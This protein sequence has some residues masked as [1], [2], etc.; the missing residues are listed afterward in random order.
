M[1]RS[2]FAM[3]F[4]AG[5]ALVV[6]LHPAAALCQATPSKDAPA[7][8]AAAPASPAQADPNAAFL[9]KASGIY[10]ST[11][12]Q[13]LTGF[14]CAVHPDWAGIFKTLEKK[15][16]TTADERTAYEKDVALLNSLK[17]T[18]HVR[19]TGPGSGMDWEPGTMAPPDPDSLEMVDHMHQATGQN[20]Q[21]FLQFW[22]PL[23]NG[24]V[25]PDT[26][27][28]ITVEKTET[29]HTIHAVDGSTN[30]TEVLD[31][32]NVL[33]EFIVEM[34]GAKITF[35]PTYKPTPNGLL[36]SSFATRIQPPGATAEKQQKMNVGVEYQTVKGFLVLHTLTMDDVGMGT[37][38]YTFD[39]CTVNPAP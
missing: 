39:G 12:K 2:G 8:A 38:A 15:P 1:F 13:G 26:T 29:G 23:V 9:A 21:G 36:V 33:K 11:T 3:P 7:P 22:T 19:L 28:G 25:I 18:L 16:A 6:A 14:D 27:S 5:I 31:T 37:F 4:A 24:S 17:I 20:L 10:Y 35:N 30:I 34:Q 32:G